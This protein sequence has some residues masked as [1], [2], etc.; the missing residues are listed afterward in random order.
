MQLMYNVADK[1]TEMNYSYT[2]L[3][4]TYFNTICITI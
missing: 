2:F 4:I 3:H 1:Y